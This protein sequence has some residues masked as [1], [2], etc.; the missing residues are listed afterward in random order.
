MADMIDPK[1]IADDVVKT[2]VDK[3]TMSSDM[4]PEQINVLKKLKKSNTQPGK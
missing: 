4:I 2:S 1:N 3:R